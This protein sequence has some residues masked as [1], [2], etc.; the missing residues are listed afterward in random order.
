M[1]DSLYAEAAVLTAMRDFYLQSDG[2][3]RG[4]ALYINPNGEFSHKLLPEFRY[5]KSA[6]LSGVVQELYF[7]EQ[8]K[9]FVTR[10]RPVRPIPEVDGCFENVWRKYREEKNAK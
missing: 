9:R 7:S 6:D 10:L 3:T 5:K 8:E 1:R 4:S 2:G